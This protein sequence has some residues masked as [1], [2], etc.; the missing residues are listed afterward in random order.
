M[1]LSGCG[2]RETHLSDKYWIFVRKKPAPPSRRVLV[3]PLIKLSQEQFTDRC[4]EDDSSTSS[5]DLTVLQTVHFQVDTPSCLTV[6][7][8]MTSRVVVVIADV[9]ESFLSVQF[10]SHIR[11]L[12]RIM[13]IV[14]NPHCFR[15]ARHIHCNINQ[16]SKYKILVSSNRNFPV[17]VKPQ[18]RG[19]DTK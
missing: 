12:G 6:F 4:V 11:E 5:N 2:K 1:V 18:M 19:R 7:L 15:V 9:K 13:W 17:S 3:T 8:E 10:A 14:A 16:T